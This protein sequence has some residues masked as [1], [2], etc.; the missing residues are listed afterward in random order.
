M[1]ARLPKFEI[2]SY[3]VCL[4][5]MSLDPYFPPDQ[6][7]SLTSVCRIIGSIIEYESQGRKKL[8]CKDSIFFFQ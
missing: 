7:L 8:N 5:K 3:D 2:P 6:D 4:C 1:S